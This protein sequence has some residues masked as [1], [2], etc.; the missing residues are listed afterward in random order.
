MR[1]VIVVS[2][3]EERRLSLPPEWERFDTELPILGSYRRLAGRAVRENWGPDVLVVQDD[4]RLRDQPIHH[5]GAWI[6]AYTAY[7][8]IPLH[9]CPHAFTATQEGWS[10]LHRLWVSPG[11]RSICPSFT[12]AVKTRGARC[13]DMVRLIA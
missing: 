8:A 2:F 7:R 6:T 13:L 3:Y 1:R 12:Y 11:D 5:A 9:I 4:V 10:L